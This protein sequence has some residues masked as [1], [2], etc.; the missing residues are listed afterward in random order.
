MKIMTQKRTSE[1]TH[2]SARFRNQSISSF[3]FGESCEIW[4]KPMDRILWILWKKPLRGRR[5][6]VSSIWCYRS[7]ERD[8]GSTEGRRKIPTAYDSI[9]QPR[10]NEC[11]L[12][13]WQSNTFEEQWSR[14][15]WGPYA[16]QSML[17][18]KLPEW[19]TESY[20]CSSGNFASMGPNGKYGKL[21]RAT[22]RTYTRWM[23]TLEEFS[24]RIVSVIRSTN[25][26]YHLMEKRDPKGSTHI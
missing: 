16:A 22:Y 24:A 9:K 14:R 2:A 1:V 10:W 3:P 5:T 15:F 12:W 19:P 7:R 23:V 26:C 17:V 20:H 6:D 25:L 21:G 8:R 11:P 13:E 4:E 18:L